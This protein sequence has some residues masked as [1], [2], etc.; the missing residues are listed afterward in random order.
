MTSPAKASAFSDAQRA[1]AREMIARVQ[2]G[3]NI[4]LEEI[5][6]FLEDSSKQ[7]QGQISEKLPALPKR[8]D[9]DFF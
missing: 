2:S 5:A 7:L 1:K 8:R 9:V 4:P 6:A 3:E